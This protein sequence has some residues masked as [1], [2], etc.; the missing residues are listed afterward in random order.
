MSGSAR[1]GDLMVREGHFP[2]APRI[3]R[4][5]PVR[6]RPGAERSRRGAA[7]AR[8]ERVKALFTRDSLHTSNDYFHAAVIL[9]HGAVPEDFLLA[10]DF[11]VAA[12][13]LGKNDKD[14][15]WLAASAEDRFLMNLGRA[16]RF[17]T[18]FRSEGDGPVKLYPVDA[19]VTDA[20]RRLMGAH[21]LAEAR[22]HEAEL[23]KP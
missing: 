5:G 11:C 22:A 19:S 21:S 7:R 12:I 8:R 23:N 6:R 9:Q 2:F 17:A 18:Q 16:Q 1:H 13:I 3:H 4:P 10:H 20:L 15:R 14:T